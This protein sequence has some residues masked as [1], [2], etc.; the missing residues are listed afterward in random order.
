[1]YYIRE[2]TCVVIQG[3]SW[4]DLT[5]ASYLRSIVYDIMRNVVSTQIINT[6]IN[7]YIY[8]YFTDEYEVTY[9]VMLSTADSGYYTGYMGECG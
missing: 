1:M 5:N 9:G 3:N 6:H 8:I 4:D 2:N 7:I